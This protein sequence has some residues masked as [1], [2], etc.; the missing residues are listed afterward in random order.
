M[1]KKKFHIRDVNLDYTQEL[2]EAKLDRTNK[3]V[4]K[5]RKQAWGKYIKELRETKSAPREWGYGRAG[6][7]TKN[8]ERISADKLDKQLEQ[9]IE[10]LLTEEENEHSPTARITSTFSNPKTKHSW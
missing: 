3:Q 1:S 4:N 7:R 2:M 6:W 5:N 8:T 9:L 10:D